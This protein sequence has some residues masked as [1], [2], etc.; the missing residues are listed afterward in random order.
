VSTSN[1]GAF[2]ALVTFNALDESGVALVGT[3]G[4]LEGVVGL[5]GSAGVKVVAGGAGVLAGSTALSVD[6]ESSGAD[7]NTGSVVK[8]LFGVAFD[9]S[10]K[11]AVAVFALA[12]DTSLAFAVKSEETIKTFVDAG[13]VL[14]K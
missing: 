2:K 8:V 11:S 13:F 1:I 6:V 12:I 5:A 14:E 7:G 4:A 10:L 3:L 9:A